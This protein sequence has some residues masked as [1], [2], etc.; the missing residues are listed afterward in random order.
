MATLSVS[1][2]EP[3]QT[4]TAAGDAGPWDSSSYRAFVEKIASIQADY[5]RCM[6][7]AQQK[8]QFMF[9]EGYGRFLTAVQAVQNDLAQGAQPAYQA[10]LKGAG[11]DWGQGDAQAHC[12]D[13]WQNYVN[14]LHELYSNPE[15]QKA[16]KAYSEFVITLAEVQGSP[17]ASQRLTEGYQRLQQ[18]LVDLQNQEAVKA[19]IQQSYSELVAR[20]QAAVQEGY[21]RL[22]AA[23]QGFSQGL[24]DAWL[25]ANAQQRLELAVRDFLAALANISG[26][27]EDTGKECATRAGQQFQDAWSQLQAA[28]AG[29]GH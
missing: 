5:V 1:P 25:K 8:I 13:A 28:R 3:V 24:Q 2:L 17:V 15:M 22:L 14:A 7:E 21:A 27:A 26:H 12:L 29:Q 23:L 19:K 20:F 9:N 11:Q 6:Q 18:A 10:F 16:E 4:G